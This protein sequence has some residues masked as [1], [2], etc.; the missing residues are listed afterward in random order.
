VAQQQERSKRI[1]EVFAEFFEQPTRD[2]LR[3]LLKNNLGEFNYLDFKE[4]WLPK[5]ARGEFA[6]DILGFANSGGGVMVIGVKEHTDR[7]LSSVG[8]PE[9][10]DKTDIHNSVK[11]FLP[12]EIEYDV[13]D[14]SFK[15]SE[16][17]AITG[18]K[19][20]ALLV[21]DRPRHLPFISTADGTE[22]TSNTI[23]VRVGVSTSPATHDQLQKMLNRRIETGHSTD[24]ELTLREH[25]DELKTLYAESTS[26]P[27]SIPIDMISLVIN[28]NYPDESYEAFITRM[29]GSKKRIIEDFLQQ[30]RRDRIV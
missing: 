15:E 24:R 20:Q 9:L 5:E 19:F 2:S 29:I 14:F 4:Q 11:K 18:K 25:I 23:Y 13:L 28:P 10:K 22:I 1:Y 30:R 17:A 7:S 21:E 26:K 27:S 16:D 3:E 6:R 8:I 12:E